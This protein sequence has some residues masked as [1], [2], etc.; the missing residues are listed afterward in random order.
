MNTW[1]TQMGYPV[2]HVSNISESTISL[3]QERFL[4]NPTQEK[5]T[6]SSPY[7]YLN[8]LTILLFLKLVI[9]AKTYC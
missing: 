5:N 4:L 2:I 9:K 7:M 8:L 3:S 1:L 6:S